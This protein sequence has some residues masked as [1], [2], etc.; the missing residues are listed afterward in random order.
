[1]E[2][3]N[4]LAHPCPHPATVEER[5]RDRFYILCNAE[6]GQ[7]CHWAKRFDGLPDPPF[8]SER[9]EAALPL[10]GPL[11]TAASEA[12]TRAVLATGLI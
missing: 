2:T 7:P 8:H 4:P 3:P 6:S 12:F 10:T 5:L 1:M 11:D 9:L